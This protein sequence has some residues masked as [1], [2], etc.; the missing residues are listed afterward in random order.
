MIL[1]I[2]NFDSFTYNLYQQISQLGVACEVLRQDKVDEN[3]IKHYQPQAIV[4]SPGPGTPS[5]IENVVALIREHYQ[6][7]P[8]LGVCLGHQ[9]IA[10]AFGAAVVRTEPVH[11][12]TAQVFHGRRDVF[13]EVTLPMQTARYHSLIVARE[14][15]PE[16]FDVIAELADETV[17]AIKHKEYPCYGVQFHPESLLTPEGDTLMKSFLIR[18][19]VLTNG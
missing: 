4:I 2:D 3:T 9:A 6:T 19:G 17:M 10:Q 13:S 16:I 14:T 18:A 12:K 15:L 7:L 8:I 1:L 11:G 5:E